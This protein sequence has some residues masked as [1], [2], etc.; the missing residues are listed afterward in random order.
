LNPNGS[1]LVEL[2]QFRSS[3]ENIYNKG[4][5]DALEDLGLD[6]RNALSPSTRDQ[7]N[8]VND[9]DNTNRD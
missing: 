9:I 2:A 5:S 7:Y 8:H 1:T 3:L 6:P 4:Y